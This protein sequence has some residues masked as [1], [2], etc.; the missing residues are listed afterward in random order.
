MPL[1]VIAEADV[2]CSWCG[3]W[4]PE[5]KALD[6]GALRICIDAGHDE[7]HDKSF[8]LHDASTPD[9]EAF[10]NLHMAQ[11]LK[12]KLESMGYEVVMTRET[13][14]CPGE[15]LNEDGVISGNECIITRY[16][17]ANK[18]YCDVFISV[19]C[20]AAGAPGAHGTSTWM[21][22]YLGKYFPAVKNEGSGTSG[23]YN[24]NTVANEKDRC[25][26][27]FGLAFWIQEDLTS[28]L[29][30][31]DRG[32]WS[33]TVSGEG[34]I[35]V[36]RYTKMP[37][38]LA[39]VAFKTNPGDAA[40]LNDPVFRQNAAEG[41][42]KGIHDYFTKRG[43]TFNL[44]SPAD[45]FI[46]DPDGLRIG[47]QFNEIPGATYS[48]VDVDGD[49]DLDDSVRIPDRKIGNYTIAVVAEPGAEPTDTYTFMISL[50]GVPVILA[51]DVQIGNIPSEPYVIESTPT[52]IVP[53]GSP[54]VTV[55]FPTANV[56]VQDGVTLTASASD[57]SGVKEVRLYLREPDGTSGTPIGYEGLSATYNGSADKWEY[58]FDTTLLP[59]GYYVVL[60]KAVDNY[61]NEGWSD[62]VLFSIRN[63][64]V[65][66]LLPASEDNKAGRTMPVK[67]SLRIAEAVD[68]EQPFVY[69]EDLEI[70]IFD[71][72]N[73]GEI[74][75]TAIFADGS[76]NYRIDTDSEMYITNFKTT[77][78]PAEY[79]VEI[80]RPNNNDFLVGSFT[81]ET[82]K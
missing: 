40:K 65:V 74:L 51:Q 30:T 45:I 79:A 68:P 67:F 2:Y 14:E 25:D 57:P 9:S 64:A 6:V 34:A 58:L 66:E 49:G 81:F 37:A 46:T 41:M 63:W 56:A 53:L 19:H 23:I 50:F 69:N 75:Q 72:S 20:D 32:V 62:V 47:K 29:G 73:P 54:V 42:A 76:T 36:L 59:D 12:T 22:D 4:Y 48:E 55:E 70:R 33:D 71:T 1:T 82:V 28:K 77:K 18:S 3:H 26:R 38:A 5:P 15:D 52:G 27:S 43:L 21:Y 61:D 24:G 80:W 35:G 17:T 16:R 31:Y 8:P 39:E 7:T 13:D 60:A 10:L 11:Q 44:C 78:K